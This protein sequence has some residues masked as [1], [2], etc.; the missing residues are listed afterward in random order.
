[1]SNSIEKNIEI[2]ENIYSSGQSDLKYPNEMFVR[3]FNKYKAKKNI[4]TALDFGFGTGANLVHL[5]ESGCDVSGVEVSESAIQIVK[6]K[7]NE[8]GL[9]ADLKLIDDHNI[10]YKENSFDVVVA[11][12]VLVYN[13]LDSFKLTMNEISRV[14]KKGG[15]FIG[16]MT[17][18]GDQTYKISDKIGKYLY[19]SNVQTQDGAICIIVD[20]VDLDVFFPN[21]KLSVGEYFFEFEGIT[22]KHLVVVYEN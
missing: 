7:L 1:M 6:N 4:K 8:K 15:L 5:V 19:R 13:D 14:L 22:S 17:A 20:S 16:T 18:V 21:K 11:W 2:W 3:V 10:P 9:T 12:Q